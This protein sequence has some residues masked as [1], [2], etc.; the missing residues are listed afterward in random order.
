M[1]NHFPVLHTTSHLE[2]PCMHGT[3]S[4]QTALLEELAA[5]RQQT[6]TLA[7][8]NAALRRRISA[9]DHSLAFLDA[10]IQSLPTPIFVKEAQDLRFVRLNKAGEALLGLSQEEIIGK[11]D[12]DFFPLQEADLFTGKDRHVIACGQLE[13]IAEEPIH[14]RTQGVRLLHTKKI[15][16]YDNLGQPQYLL[17]ISEDITERKG[18]EKSLQTYA[19]RL[20]TLTY[21]NRLVS[22]SLHM[23]DVLQ[24]MARATGQLMDAPLVILAIA[25]ETAQTLEVVAFSNETLSADCPIKTVQFGEGPYGWIALH[26]WPLQVPNVFEDD[27]FMGLDWWQRHQLQSYYGVPIVHQDTLIGV[28]SMMG[29]KPFHIGSMESTLLDSLMAQ[30]II[31]VEHARRFQAMQAQ[32]EALSRANQA[33]EHEIA[34]RKYAEARLQQAQ[35]ELEDRVRERTSDLEQANNRLQAEIA[36]RTQAETALRQRETQLQHL[37]AIGRIISASLDI[38]EVYQRFAE[39]VAQLLPF[40]RIT[41]TNVDESQQLATVDYVWGMSVEGRGPGD[42]YP[43]P[44]TIAEEV[45]RSATGKLV[46]I[47]HDASIQQKFAGS[48]SLERSG[49]RSH[50]VHPLLIHDHVIG[51]LYLGTAEPNA[52][53]EQALNLVESVSNQI[54]GAIANAQHY[55]ERKRLETQLQQAY[56]MEAIGTLAGGIAHDF[57]NLLAVIIGYT[58]L[59]SLDLATGNG[60][61]SYLQEILTAC[62]RAKSLVQQILTFSRQRD[63]ERQ[64]VSLCRV[65]NET[66][67]LLRASLP[68]T[69]AFQCHIDP[70]SGAVMADPTQMHQ[71]LMNLCTN[72]EHAMRQNGGLLEVRLEAVRVDASFATHHPPLRP[73]PHARLIVR[74]TGQGIPHEVQ[75]RIFDPFFTTKAVGEGTGMGLAVVHGIVTNHDGAIAVE[76]QQGCGTKFTIYLPQW[77]EAD[78]EDIQPADQLPAGRGNILFVDDEVALIR[79]GQAML[80]HLGYTVTAYTSS[81]EAFTCFQAAPHTFDLVITD[82]TMPHMTGEMLS[83]AIRQVRPDV[84]IILCTGFSHVITQENALSM[85]INAFLQKPL[86]MH[87]LGAAIQRVLDEHAT[88]LTKP[89]S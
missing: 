38:Q 68:T 50:L 41:L 82:Q 62:R 1:P 21:L 5:L 33:L 14:T 56:K 10:I 8:E 53:D 63:P 25:D 44:G 7:A 45:M 71:V 42:A 15:P 46:L 81:D 4:S 11:T 85:G 79:A 66:L 31:A 19:S 74:D 77:K 52:Y 64:P 65:V 36:E 20:Q 67:Q 89:A 72:A 47:D 13:D 34:E 60:A 76:S 28:L 54:A 29:R 57:N 35:E 17:A 9:Q 84:P 83:Q 16:I 86:T 75:A 87:D 24:E 48:V 37:T 59:L 23:E 22:S 6:Q 51:F 69:I 49:L 70:Q 40:D 12:Y 18:A 73:G 78:T 27:R 58:E 32:A 3:E 26:R 2:G 61:T 30:A 55:A 80:T 88:A 43:L 39:E